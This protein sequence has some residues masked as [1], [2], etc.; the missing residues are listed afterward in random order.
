MSFTAKRK[1]GTQ[2]SISSSQMTVEDTLADTLAFIAT[3]NGLVTVGKRPRPV[4]ADGFDIAMSVVILAASVT[5]DDAI[6]TA[7]K[8]KNCVVVTVTVSVS[9]FVL[10][11]STVSTIATED[12]EG[13]L[14]VGVSNG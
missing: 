12:S 6:G 2:P 3:T 7:D 13:L 8:V 10:V 4:T 11:M 9:V 1:G 5:A 14:S